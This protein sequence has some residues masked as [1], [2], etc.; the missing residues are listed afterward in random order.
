[1]IPLCALIRTQK[2]LKTGRFWGP[3]CPLCAFLRSRFSACGAPFFCTT[4]S[5]SVGWNLAQIPHHIPYSD[6]YAHRKSLRA[7]LFRRVK[8]HC[9]NICTAK[10]RILFA[11]KYGYLHRP[12][13]GSY[14]HRNWHTTVRLIGYSVCVVGVS[15][16]ISGTVFHLQSFFGHEMDYA[17]L[18]DF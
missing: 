12:V 1:M 4:G 6:K 3:N 11:D 9:E 14:R 2:P 10:S 18:G 5:I 8:P 7:V 13:K 15:R 17:D 16:G